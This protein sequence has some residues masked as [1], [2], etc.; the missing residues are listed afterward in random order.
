MVQYFQSRRCHLSEECAD[1]TLDRV[2]RKLA[3]GEQVD[4]L[5]PYAYGVA[6]Y[7]LLEYRRRPDR[8]PVEIPPTLPALTDI[9]NEALRRE[10]LDCFKRCLQ[11]LDPEEARL[12]LRYWVHDEKKNREARREQ[13]EEHGVSSGALRLRIMRI[14]ARFIACFEKCA[15][16]REKR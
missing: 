1:E 13:A 4:R 5:L 10:S 2:A 9:L 8:E 6:K 12:L 3:E 11:K 16:P 7:V 14:R 15:G